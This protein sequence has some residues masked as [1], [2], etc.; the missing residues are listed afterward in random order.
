MSAA[1]QIVYKLNNK[2]AL[3]YIVVVLEDD[4]YTGDV[5]DINDKIQYHIKKDIKT[6]VNLR[7]EKYYEE[8]DIEIFQITNIRNNI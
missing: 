7:S 5:V 1:Y 8:E 2:A 4:I 6:Y 3:K